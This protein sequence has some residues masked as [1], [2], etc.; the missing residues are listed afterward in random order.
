MRRGRRANPVVIGA[1]VLGAVA[2]GAAV[3]VVWG[4]GR[5]FRRT[6]T[7]VSYFLSLIHI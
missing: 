6:V 4:S 1:F 5:F 7:F 2:L 3:V